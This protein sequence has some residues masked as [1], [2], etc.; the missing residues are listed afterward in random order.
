MKQSKRALALG[1][2]VSLLLAGA[3]GF[4]ATEPSSAERQSFE[5]LQDTVINLLQALVDQGVI[6][7]A[8]AQEL[9]QQAKQKAAASAAKAAQV[10]AQDRNAIRVPY[11]PKIV[12]DSIAKRVAH[13]V[14][15]KVVASV[16]SEAKRE[17][18]GVPAAL[19]DWLSRV[20]VDG[21]VAVRAQ[22]DLFSTANQPN[23]IL[24]FNAIN[25]YGGIAKVPGYGPFLDTTENRDRMRVRAHL[26]LVAALTP[27]WSAGL[28]LSSG[29]LTD[30]SSESQTLGT[31]SARYTVGFDEAYVRWNSAPAGEFSAVSAQA[32]R[33]LNP[34]FAPTQL[35]YADDLS[36]EGAS[37][38]FRQGFGPARG[39]SRSNVFA[40]LG[41]TPI[42]EVPF[43]NS[44]NK[45]MLAAQLGTDLH[46][47][48]GSD[49]LRVAAAY[50][51]FLHVTGRLNDPNQ[52]GLFNYTAPAFVRNGNTMFDI[53][54]S[55][56]P[57]VNLYAL[58][59]KFRLVDVAATYD[60]G[61]GRYR[62]GLSIDA[63][64][65]VGYNLRDIQNL[66]PLNLY[67]N[68]AQNSG[69][70]GEINFG[71]PEV[72]AFGQWS[73]KFGYRYVQSDAVIDAWTDADFHEG[74]TNARGYYIWGEAGLADH[75]RVRARYLSGN[76]IVGPRYGLDILQL[77]LLSSF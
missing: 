1:V 27:Q 17:K 68:A 62:L 44:Q 58:A 46:W 18:W 4:A 36:F 28:R 21:D 35:V 40:T 65:N 20:R 23:S 55:T 10:A 30:P 72:E 56:D 22:A 25:Q 29:S 26:G 69:Y 33:F 2:L 71:D 50:Y 59:A 63:V 53:A 61:F 8:K 42:L 11:V 57:T 34:Y 47:N 6:S 15:P 5:E 51:D 37:A 12:E 64:R 41:A 76:E 38:S 73:V 67:S 3:P 14:Q 75:V 49:R 74:G 66:N 31:A 77:D 24:D 19:P 54:N 16:V 43:A 52:P 32:G 9:V 70:V 39:A 60:R 7:R 45:W 48:D 13:E